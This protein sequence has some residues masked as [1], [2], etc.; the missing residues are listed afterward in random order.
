MNDDYEVGFAKTNSK[1][2]DGTIIQEAVIIADGR[3][4]IP[5]EGQ[6]LLKDK[7]PVLY[8]VIQGVYGDAINETDTEFQIPD[9][10]GKA[11]VGRRSDSTVD[12][13]QPDG[14]SEGGPETSG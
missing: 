5:A 3:E 11:L 8:K 1:L 14:S 2:E 7:Y 13:G 10:R 9:F 4:E 6:M 12:E